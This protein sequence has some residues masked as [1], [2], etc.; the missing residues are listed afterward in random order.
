MLCAPARRGHALCAFAV[1]FASRVFFLVSP[2]AS[3]SALHVCEQLR[4]NL[5]QMGQLPAGACT[6]IKTFAWCSSKQR[7]CHETWM[8]QRCKRSCKACTIGPEQAAWEQNHEQ[9]RRA[10]SRVMSPGQ[11]TRYFVDAGA[12]IGDSIED[13]FRKPSCWS[14]QGVAFPTYMKQEPSC[15]PKYPAWLPIET[16]RQYCAVGLEPNP[17]HWAGLQ[18]KAERLKSAYG[19]NV[20]LGNSAFSHEDGF[21]NFGIDTIHGDS[22]G[23]SLQ[24][25]RHTT[26]KDGKRG[27]GP[28]LAEQNT[29]L[30]RTVD[31]AKYLDA[32]G[33]PTAADIV[34]KIDIEGS[35]YAVLQRLLH[36]GVLCRRVTDLFVEW[37]EQSTNMAA[38]RWLQ[39]QLVVGS[40]HNSTR[41]ANR[42]SA[43]PTRLHG[44]H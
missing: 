11:C 4:A 13:W 28:T 40:S 34:L 22:V 18:R 30:V 25:T 26:G 37:H 14:C 8:Q 41:P 15:H 36:S 31:A 39:N 23:S 27:H 2:M 20:T 6:D 38:Y 43:C 12:N 10:C 9:T 32:I 44:W 21:A 17:R 7:G 3:A 42:S 33:D 16:R 1:L 24:L 19:S 5:P 35:E 29:T